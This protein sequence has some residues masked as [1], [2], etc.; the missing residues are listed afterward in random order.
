MTVSLTV[1]GVSF[2]YPQTGE[3][4]W[5]TS[6]TNWASA[7]TTG[8]L[9]KAGGTFTLTAEVDF[10]GT[11]G[12]KVQYLKSKGTNIAAAGVVRL[13]NAETISWRNN[14]NS[15]DLALT[16]SAAD[17]LTFGGT[18][19][20]LSG[21]IVNADIDASAAIA[22]SK[23]AS[24]TADHVLINN[25]SGVMSSE[26]TLAKSRG[27]AAAD[28][29]SV[30]FP[31]T[32]VIVTE[33]GTQTLTNKTIT[34]SV[35]ASFSNS[36]TV[37]LPTGTVTLA[38]LTGAEI[39]TNKDIDG[40][41]A[42]NTRRITLPKD[43]AA[44]IAALTRKQG[45]LLYDTTNN[46]VKYDD[47]ASL[48][49]LASSS[50]A[51][52]TAA[53]IVTSFYPTIVSAVKSVSSANYTVLTA[54]G[55]HTV[56]VST[57]A[58]TRTITLPAAA[59]NAGR[60][61][62][63]VKT[64]N[65]A[66]FVTIDGNASETIDGVTTQTIYYQYGTAQIVCDG[67]AW[68]TVQPITERGSYTPTVTNLT[69]MTIGTIRTSYFYRV[70]NMVTVTFSFDSSTTSG[71]STAS[72][73]SITI[74][75]A[76]NFTASNQLSGTHSTGDGATITGPESG[77]LYADATSDYAVCEFKSIGTASRAFVGTFTYVIL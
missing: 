43:T 73:A 20:I 58:S 57:G 10:G 23:L 50:T 14:A 5:G 71:G 68:Y 30:T 13:A 52:S 47:G 55:Y 35:A 65:G 59:N 61:L 28:M 24:G 26:A 49:T 11:F 18:K 44:N 41:T 27:G 3:D 37:T 19:V 29:S 76:S 39:F 54:D 64:D 70:G 62:Y 42:A 53:G 51:T 77:K 22:R 16:A 8:M 6:A 75:I 33:A 2:D 38:T 48:N 69:N 4:G 74:P 72:A 45:T 60:T 7:V 36:G 32:G 67:S 21:A 34:G 12:L 17:N 31:S 63:I 56:L 66:G 9:Q 40:G 15:A 1:N 46:V 25:G